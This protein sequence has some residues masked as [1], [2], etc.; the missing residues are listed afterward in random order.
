M[1]RQLLS[2]PAQLSAQVTASLKADHRHGHRSRMHH[3]PH[4]A[5]SP[6]PSA[7]DVR[8]AC[9][10][11]LPLAAALGDGHVPLHA[12]AASQRTPKPSQGASTA[13][14]EAQP[15]RRH[16]NAKARPVASSLG[17]LLA[18]KARVGAP[19]GRSRRTGAHEGSTAPPHGPDCSGAFPR[20]PFMPE[21][22]GARS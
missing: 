12:T 15:R 21:T 1:H 17:V 20:E 8:T 18:A 5:A 7:P 13:S 2:W 19:S 9:P 10:R 22:H 16:G 14:G 11:A 3:L 4:I 6:A